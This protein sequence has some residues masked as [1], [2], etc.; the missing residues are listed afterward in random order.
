MIR[1][2]ADRAEINDLLHRYFEGVHQND[3]EIVS[4]VF[5]EDALVES[6]RGPVKGIEK[7]GFISQRASYRP[8]CES[9][10]DSTYF[11]TGRRWS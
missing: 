5:S 11:L 9:V 1:E 10:M 8:R 6:S 2:L 4:S 3:L 7:S